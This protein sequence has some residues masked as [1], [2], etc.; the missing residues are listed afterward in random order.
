M[1][2]A[3]DPS[4]APLRSYQV[5][6]SGEAVGWE[7]KRKIAQA[8]FVPRASVFCGRPPGVVLAYDLRTTPSVGGLR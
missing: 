2:F 6:V 7:A 8:C 5:T 4:S 1:F 3:F